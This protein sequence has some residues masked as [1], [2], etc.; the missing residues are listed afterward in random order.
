MYL[1]KLP[2]KHVFFYQRNKQEFKYIHTYMYLKDTYIYVLSSIYKILKIEIQKSKWKEIVNNANNIYKRK[3][4][5]PLVKLINKI[6]FIINL[7]SIVVTVF[8]K[9][10]KKVFTDTQPHIVDNFTCFN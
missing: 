4:K 3:F 7:L 10:K 1:C 2:E 8:S 5:M 9:K 6:L